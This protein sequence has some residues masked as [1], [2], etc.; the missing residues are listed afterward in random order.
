MMENISYK[1]FF[2]KYLIFTLVI[3]IIFLITSYIVKITQKHWAI[4][5]SSNVEKVLEENE[6]GQWILGNE[7]KIY[8][9]MSLNGA[10]FEARYRKTGDIYNVLIIRINSFYGPL[11]AVF[12][13]DKD[14]N[15]EFIGYSSLHGRILE[16]LKNNM[17]DKRISY[18]KNKIPEI[19][20]SKY[21]MGL[22]NE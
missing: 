20:N 12:S 22:S 18:W 19:I 13:C 4:N 6:S 17:N 5:L 21:F 9:P 15:V 7:I 3:G 2:K 11:A 16:Q 10:C 8:N 14:N 1:D